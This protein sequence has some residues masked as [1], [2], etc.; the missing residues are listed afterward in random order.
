MTK[1]NCKFCNK[2][3][4]IKLIEDHLSE[5]ILNFINDKS[6]YLIEFI[7]INYITNKTYQMF[8]IFGIK[9]K[10]SHIDIFLRNKWCECCD[11]MSTLDVFE[12]VDKTYE[13]IKF[14]TLI[15]KYEKANQFLYSYDMGS[16]TEIFFRIIK[17]LEGKEKNTNIEL[18]YRNE[19]FKVKCCYYKKCKN[20]ATCIYFEY[21][22]CNECI[23]NIDEYEDEQENILK[24]TNSPR[25]GIC[26]YENENENEN[27]ADFILNK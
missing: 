22:F 18:L 24:I 25:T 15:S 27:Y 14:N 9:C 4:G 16:T 11:H 19:P 5:C 2:K 26:A 8:A 21:L 6:G 20:Y 3:Y 17:K 10:F 7:S 1:I 12:E 13:S 23:I